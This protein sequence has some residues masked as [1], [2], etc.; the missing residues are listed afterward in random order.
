M[1]A[2]M[3]KSTLKIKTYLII[4]KKKL[5]KTKKAQNWI[6]F[7]IPSVSKKKLAGVDGILQLIQPLQL[8]F[9][10]G[11]PAGRP[12]AGALHVIVFRRVFDALVEGHGDGAAQVG[13]DADALLGPHEDLPSVD[14]GIE[15][16]AFLPD[17]THLGQGED[18]ES[19]AVGEDG[20]T[21]LGLKCRRNTLDL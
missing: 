13:L 11:E 6:L 5:V 3:S 20:E 16:D 14:V 10:A 18:L 7:I 17:G 9:A 19:A 15:G 8:G 21:W 12:V 4:G 2:N 1:I